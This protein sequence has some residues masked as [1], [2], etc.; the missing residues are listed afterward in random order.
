MFL[1]NVGASYDLAVLDRH[2]INYMMV[3]G[4]TADPAPTRRMTDY[5]RDEVILRDHAAEFGL[6]VGYL[7]WAVWIV[8]R[9]AGPQAGRERL[10]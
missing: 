9:V 7:D 6:P 2:V 5:R 10:Q 3:L 8:M 4:L 1:R